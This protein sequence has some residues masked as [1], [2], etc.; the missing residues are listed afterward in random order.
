[1]PA[2]ATKELDAADLLVFTSAWVD[3]EDTRLPLLRALARRH[4]V[5]VVNANWREGV[6]VVPGQ[7]GSVVLDAKG[8]V[9]AHA[10]PLAGVVTARLP[11]G[12]KRELAP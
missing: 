1:M 9:V 5:A 2:E 12:E 4:R 11:S 10:G 6:V 7:G 8:R 3:E